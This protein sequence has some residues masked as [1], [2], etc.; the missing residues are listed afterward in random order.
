MMKRLLVVALLLCGVAPRTAW[1][2]SHFF[3][4]QYGTI[5]ISEQGVVSKGSELVALGQIV[6]SH[7][8]SLGTVNFTAGTLIEGTIAGGGAFSD[9]GSS[10]VITG[11]GNQGVPKGPIFVGAYVGKVHWK[12]I[13]QDGQ[14]LTFQLNGRILGTLYTGRMVELTSKQTITATEDQLAQGIGHIEIGKGIG[15]P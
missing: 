9:F 10:F 8:H 6:A 15:F 2:A 11:D 12:L 3:T 5:S 4:N 13:S 14:K 1:A 7:G